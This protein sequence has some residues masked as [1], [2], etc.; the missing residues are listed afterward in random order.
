MTRPVDVLGELSVAGE[1]GEQIRVEGQGD[2]ISVALPSLGVG[3]SLAGKATGRSK[4]KAAVGK[5]HATLRRADLTL[6]VNVAGRPIARLAPQSE[7]T[8][9][10]RLLGLGA[11]ELKPIGLLLAA[12][13]R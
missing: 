12:F 7:A 2:A 9:L 13:R 5:L 10:S 4:R 11:M 8:L 6:Q 3:R 1:R